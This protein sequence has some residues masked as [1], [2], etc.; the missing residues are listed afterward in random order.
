MILKSSASLADVWTHCL[1]REWRLTPS[2]YHRLMAATLAGQV[3]AGIDGDRIIAIGGAFR[4]LPD[5]PGTCWLSILPDLPVKTVVTA[6][7]LMRSAIRADADDRGLVC[8]VR[9]GAAKGARLA[10]ALGFVP[11]REVGPFLEMAWRG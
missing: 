2:D 8:V 5:G 1:Q 10:R 11:A 6:A 9:D 4:P 3:H 7:L